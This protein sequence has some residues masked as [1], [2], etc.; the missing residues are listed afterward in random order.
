MFS[1]ERP[2][3]RLRQWIG[4]ATPPGLHS[5]TIIRGAVVAPWNSPI[6][7]IDTS[8]PPARRLVSRQGQDGTSPKIT[9]TGESGRIAPEG[10]TMRV[11]LYGEPL[12]GDHVSQKLRTGEHRLDPGL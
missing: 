5:H 9:P 3:P 7:V 6:I 4:D 8:E 2:R 10:S 1:V 12:A 11:E